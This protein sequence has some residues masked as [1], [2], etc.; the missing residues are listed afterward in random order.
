MVRS[1]EVPATILKK[2]IPA[3][4]QT[5]AIKAIA[6]VTSNCNCLLWEPVVASFAKIP[7]LNPIYGALAPP[8]RV[9]PLFDLKAVSCSNWAYI[10]VLEGEPD[11]FPNPRLQLVDKRLTAN[12]YIVIIVRRNRNT[13]SK[14]TRT[15]IQ[16]VSG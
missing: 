1:P 10:S 6:L 8:S 5:R 11:R 3:M 12:S 7:Q 9:N 4:A 16:G 15:T 2:P 13:E 14:G